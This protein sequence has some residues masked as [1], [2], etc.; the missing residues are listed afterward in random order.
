MLCAC[1]IP[2][3]LSPHNHPR[4]TQRLVSMVVRKTGSRGRQPGLN[5]L[6]YPLLAVWPWASNLTSVCLS[7]FIC[8]MKVISNSLNK[9]LWEVSVMNALKNKLRDIKMS[10]VYLSKHWFHPGIT[11]LEVVRSTLPTRVREGLTE[12]PWKQSK[13]IAWLVIALS[14]CLIW[15]NLVNYDWLFLNFTFSVTSAFTISPGLGFS[16][17]V[18]AIKALEPAV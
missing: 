14:H 9:E 18:E 7:S 6:L 3:S 13:E 5:Y 4:S 10:T 17:L 1:V 2:S 11:K 12:Q 16:L 8:T 15:G